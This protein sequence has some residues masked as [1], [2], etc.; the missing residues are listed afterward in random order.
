[1]A[2]PSWVVKGVRA[3]SDYTLDI[4]FADGSL[5]RYDA[6]RLLEQR[7]YAALKNLTFFKQARPMYDTVG[8]S[9]DL[10][11]SPE[12]LYEHGVPLED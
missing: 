11:I 7:G 12:H 8:W 1:M 6:H 2:E 3:H 4:S 10:D 5:R 9:E